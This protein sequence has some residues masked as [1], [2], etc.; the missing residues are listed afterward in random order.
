MARIAVAMQ[1]AAPASAGRAD[2]LGADAEDGAGAAG[3]DELDRQLLVPIRDVLQ[4]AV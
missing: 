4:S 2:G 1:E 3:A